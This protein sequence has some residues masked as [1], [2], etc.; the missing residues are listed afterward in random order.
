MRT[1]RAIVLLALLALL[2]GCG[3]TAAPQ[4]SAPASGTALTLHDAAGR[5][6][7]L[8]RRPERV[9]L[10]ESRQA[11]S[12]LFLQKDDVTRR[13]AAWG[14]DM[15]RA[16][17]DVWRKLVA[18]YPQATKVPTIGS[19]YA[20]DLSVE[21]LLAHRPDLFLMTL[22]A[23]QAASKSGLVAKLD[24]AKIAYA[25]TDFRLDPLKN[26]AVSVTLLGQV[27]GTEAT[28]KEF[29]DWY[30]AKVDPVL[31]RAKQ[32]TSHPTAFLWRAPSVAPC[33]STY[34]DANFGSLLTAVGAT[35]LADDLLDGQEGAVTPEQ[36]LASQPD[37]LVATGG[38]WGGLKNADGK[39]S[40]LHLGYDVG[41]ADA[42]A[43]LAALRSQTG[44]EH[45]KAFD[46]GRVHGIYHQFYDS[47]YN[48]VAL[49]A[50]ARWTDPTAFADV[51]PVATWRELHEKF[52]PWPVQGTFVL[53]LR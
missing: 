35:N 49:Q 3:M 9:V 1:V 15:E 22:D 24:Q 25:I 27:F 2:S 6:V 43:S 17:P 51:D 41:E 21:G 52:M 8:P 29:T 4:A 40:Y 14:T 16:A 36:V 44:F 18:T 46:T 23:Y 19:I 30:A 5:T 13:V 32:L 10:G 47:P 38:E 34:A 45:L 50:F 31:A 26:T 7:E 11:Y 33:C 12:L 39:V 28:A 53:G 48:V 20:G 42:R 37:L